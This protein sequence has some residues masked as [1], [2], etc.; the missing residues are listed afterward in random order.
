VREAARVLSVN[1]GKAQCVRHAYPH[2]SGPEGREQNTSS[3][4][5][6]IRL[7]PT[8]AR[9]GSPDNIHSPPNLCLTTEL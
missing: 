6:P 8:M 9:S 7:M 2:H 4:P 1:F 3:T 5:L